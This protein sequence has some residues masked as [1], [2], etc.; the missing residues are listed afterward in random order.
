MIAI[1]NRPAPRW[2]I[3]LTAVLALCL[4]VAATYVGWIEYQT[5]NITPFE[6][7]SQQYEGWIY[8]DWNQLK[9][10]GQCED[11]DGGWA[12]LGIETSSEFVA[13]CREWFK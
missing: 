9:D 3:A 2:L 11:T 12:A 8:A 13:G 5:R 4:A 10:A 6:R 1:K 7:D